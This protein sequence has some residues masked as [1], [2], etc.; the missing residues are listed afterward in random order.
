MFTTI[1]TASPKLLCQFV[2]PDLLVFIAADNSYKI[3]YTLLEGSFQQV[4]IY[5]LLELDY[6][7]FHARRLKVK[8]KLSLVC[9]R[10]YVLNQTI[11]VKY[12]YASLPK[13]LGKFGFVRI[14][15]DC[16]HRQYS[17]ALHVSN[18]IK[19]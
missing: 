12:A 11:S 14:Q 10:Q 1:H 7:F 4:C 16:H 5:P 9:L 15:S 18:T 19:P 3:K 8:Q 17:S 6:M 2:S 13:N